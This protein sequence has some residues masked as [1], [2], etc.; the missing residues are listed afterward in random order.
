MGFLDNL[1]KGAAQN[2]ARRIVNGV[3]D[4]A[5]NDVMGNIRGVKNSHNV[6]STSNQNTGSQ[7]TVDS[8]VFSASMVAGC[9]NKEFYYYD[10]DENKK[11]VKVKC[12]FMMPSEFV[13]YDTSVGEIDSCY[14]YSPSEVA[15]GYAEDFTGKPYIYFGFDQTSYDVVSYYL[16]N[17]AVKAGNELTKIEGS[18]VKFK[19]ERVQSGECLTVYYY[20]RRFS[21]S[22]SDLMYHI[23]LSVPQKLKGSELHKEM[24]KVLDN[25]V[26]TYSDSVIYD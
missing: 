14:V 7:R 16:K 6:S 11:S 24:E 23:V 8:E 25:V 4:D 20:Y 17:G 5:V 13:P 18:F 26:R 9:E 19:S 1:V 10:Q 15:N 21:D 12:N 22:S 3:V 2:A